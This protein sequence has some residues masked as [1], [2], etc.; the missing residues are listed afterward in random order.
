MAE[1]Y[2]EAGRPAPTDVKYRRAERDLHIAFTDGRAITL[3]AE[4]LRVN[5]P[6]AEVQGHAPGE[7]TTVAGKRNVAIT[8]IEAVGSY[9][10]RP[11]FDDGHDSGIFTW[12][13]FYARLFDSDALWAR[14][15]RE[16]TEKGLSR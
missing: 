4:F 12:A 10:I 1:P 8:A 11:T 5:S 3:G 15:E 16:L 6:S 9:A 7:R 13:W 14:Y 2:D